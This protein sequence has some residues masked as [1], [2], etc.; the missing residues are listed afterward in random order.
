VAGYGKNPVLTILERTRLYGDFSWLS[1]ML[2]DP[3]N[4]LRMFVRQWH[5][6]KNLSQLSPKFL[7]NST[8][9]THTT[10]LQP[11]FRDH[12]G[13]PVPEENFWTLRCKGRLT[14]AD[15]PCTVL[16]RFL[17]I[18]VDRSEIVYLATP[19]VFNSPGGGVPLGRS[20][21][22]FQWMSMDGQGT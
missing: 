2:W 22:N 18:A 7:M 4:V 5:L 9:H 14:E 13:E 11:F 19:L 16:H 10:V 20:P 3:F 8:K 21:W 12:P 17:D 15:L 6:V 1:S